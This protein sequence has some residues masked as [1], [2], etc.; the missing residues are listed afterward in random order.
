MFDLLFE[1]LD[2]SFEAGEVL[3]LS[4]AGKFALGRIED[5]FGGTELAV[6]VFVFDED[7]L[8][9]CGTLSW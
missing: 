2:L 5:F 9:D 6:G 4:L 7:G 8:G 3:F 1:F